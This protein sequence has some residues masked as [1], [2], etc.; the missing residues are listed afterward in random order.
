MFK[1]LKGGYLDL[2]RRIIQTKLETLKQRSVVQQTALDSWQVRTATY[3]G[4]GS[5]QYNSDWQQGV[6]PLLGQAGRTLFARSD[7]EVDALEGLQPQVK[8][9]IR[10]A[11]GLLSI[12]GR[13]YAGIDANHYEIPLPFGD[14]ELL[15]EVAIKERY[16]G[17]FNAYVEYVL[18]EIRDL[19]YDIRFAWSA[20]N[21][22]KN[23]RRRALIHQA[24]ESALLAVDLTRQGKRFVQD[25]R[26]AR[27]ILKD[28]IGRIG[29][30]E[31]IGTVAVTGHSHIDV[32][33]LWPLKE[34]IR[35]CA[36]TFSTACRL[37]EEFD[38][39]RFS[40]SQPQLYA[41]TKEH[42]PGL[43]EEIKKWVAKGRWEPTGGMWVEADCNITSG[44]SIIRQLL[45]G[46]R[47]FQQEFGYRPRTCWL[48]DVFGYPAS[49]P[50]ILKGAGIDAF[51]TCK[52]YW[53]SE[54]LF[55]YQLFHWVG[56]DGTKVTAHIPR[57]GGMYNNHLTP[58]TLNRAWD[59]HNQKVEFPETLMP[60]GHGDGGGGTTREMMEFGKRALG[61]F[62]GVPGTIMTTAEA[63]L[64]RADREARDLPEWDGELYLETHRGTL[65][66]H[67]GIKR[68][69]RKCELALRNTEILGCLAAACGYDL[70]KETGRLDEAWKLLLLNQF[71]DILPG[72]SISEVYDDAREDYGR[73]KGIVAGINTRLSTHLG[74]T[75]A[76]GDISVFNTLSWERR[77]VVSMDAE[78]VGLTDD[79][80]HLVDADGRAVP[81]QVVNEGGKRK[82]V[83]CAPVVPPVGR[84]DFRIASGSLPAAAPLQVEDRAMENSFFRVEINANGEL[85]RVFDKRASREVLPPGRVANVLQLFQDGPEREAAWNVHATFDKREYEWEGTTRVE[86]KETGPVYA[87]IQVTRTHRQSRVVQE[88]RLY[89]DLDRID[90]ATEVDWKERQTLLKAGFPVDVRSTR[91]TYE[92]QFGAVERPTHRNTS[93]DR[94]KFE[95]AAQRWVDLSEAGYGV[96][97][98][99]DCKYGHD[100]RGNMLRIS[101]LR[102]TDRPD[103]SADLG[104]HRFTYSL[105]PHRDD[106]RS[107]GTV[108]AGWELNVPL[109]AIAARSTEPPAS[110]SYLEVQGDGVVMETLKPAMDGGGLILRLYE[111]RGGRGP[112]RVTLKDGADRVEECNLV[113]ENGTR[114]KLCDRTFEFFIKPFQ[115]RTFRICPKGWGRTL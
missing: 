53:Q 2:D 38:E 42:Y 84:M 111:S 4:P 70:N 10:G 23:E 20:E 89:A 105:Y 112:V 12:S 87:S 77:D 29:Q 83:F 109:T 73:V 13:P 51:F 81:V 86:V 55:P 79:S 36:R 6:V 74:E 44:E 14:H 18:P 69:N 26:E 30:D 3:M 108:E 75:C 19:Y 21:A 101:L 98:L 48:P 103:P 9:E 85:E 67:G 95:V 46:I 54:N 110:T 50:E 114:V 28:A 99:N 82:L 64:T 113:E 76:G 72:S 52:L 96:S 66:T 91:A 43:Y 92:I 8:L 59:N 5:Y 88:I 47:F 94:Q 15:L 49:L 24:V 56:L 37:M 40:C 31:E 65:T 100:V 62:P 16:G 33:W 25:V 17:V 107:A 34:T 61:G 11:E 22:E 45:Y 58:E 1:G 32:A 63:W 80:V 90:F 41:Y 7:A 68:S 27:Q 71:H 60:V 106:W 97:L 102:G 39:Y 78:T 104:L 115:I 35:K 93:W 57:P